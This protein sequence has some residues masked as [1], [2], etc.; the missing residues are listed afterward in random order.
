MGVSVSSLAAVTLL[1]D[2]LEEEELLRDIHSSG[3]E[4][5]EETVSNDGDG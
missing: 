3:G 5:V 1:L 4:T 2:E